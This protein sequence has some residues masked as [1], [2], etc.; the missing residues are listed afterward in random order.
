MS[1]AQMASSGY[2]SAGQVAIN[3]MMRR[4]LVEEEYSAIGSVVDTDTSD[5]EEDELVKGI[6]RAS[7]LSAFRKNIYREKI[8]KKKPFVKKE[9]RTSKVVGG[10][11]RGQNE[12][13]K[14][15]RNDDDDSSVIN[16]NGSNKDSGVGEDEDDVIDDESRSSEFGD[17]GSSANTNEG[18]GK[19]ANNATWVKC[20]KCNKWRRLRGNVD[21][22]KL[23]VRWFCSMNK[24]DPARAKCSAPEEEYNEGSS[25]GNQVPLE[26]ATDHRIRKHLRLWV[27]RLQSNE[28]YERKLPTMT[29]GKKKSVTTNSKEPY[30]WVRCCNP[31]CGKFRAI[32]RFM[33]A[34]NVIMGA[35]TSF[36]TGNNSAN[37]GNGSNSVG[38]KWYCVLNTWD[39]KVASCAAPQENLPV[40]GCCPPWVLQDQVSNKD[41]SEN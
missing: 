35:D 25:N 6:D 40:D 30:E 23:P 27:R 12:V 8:D 17:Q 9:T 37:N 20:D 24:N 10:G 7:I 3:D 15:R 18:T 16:N 32:L 21:E 26:S 34:S 33:D 11:R 31:S 19:G 22:K 14:R 1:E 28:A 39:E 29:R 2:Y 41:C 4:A 5:E 13:S 38:G 36:S